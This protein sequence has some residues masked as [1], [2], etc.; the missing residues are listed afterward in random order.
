MIEFYKD[1]CLPIFPIDNQFTC[2]FIS[3]GKTAYFLTFEVARRNSA[4]LSAVTPIQRP[5][6]RNWE[7]LGW[8]WRRIFD[9][10]AVRAE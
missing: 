3:L 7:A 10:A 1:R 9:P 2:A 5:E 8:L 6:R 4:T